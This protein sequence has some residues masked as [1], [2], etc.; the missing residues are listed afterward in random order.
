MVFG[1][2]NARLEPEGRAEAVR[3]FVRD[4]LPALADGRITPLIDKVY[5]FEELPAAKAR[6]EANAQVGKIVVRVAD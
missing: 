5:A 2:S 1:V 6:M 3:G 4:V